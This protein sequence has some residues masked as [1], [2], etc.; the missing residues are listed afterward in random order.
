MARSG[1]LDP[2]DLMA[3]AEVTTSLRIV[4]PLARMAA[5]RAVP[6]LSR[7]T[8]PISGGLHHDT[9]QAIE[10]IRQASTFIQQACW[11][12]TEGL[13]LQQGDGLSADTVALFSRLLDGVEDL[14]APLDTAD[15]ALHRILPDAGNNKATHV[16]IAR[17]EA[18]TQLGE[19]VKEFRTSVREIGH[20][21]E[22][23][24]QAYRSAAMNARAGVTL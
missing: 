18:K 2:M 20:V 16:L 23:V 15:E 24:Q 3:R 4:L 17:R 6:D 11:D 12:L 19:A 22:G 13:N 1:D 7:G 5:E 9:R 21:V 8:V 10:D 14:K